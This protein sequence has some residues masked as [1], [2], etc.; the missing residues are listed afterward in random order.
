MIWLNYQHLRYFQVVAQEGSIAK[1]AEKLNLGQSAISIQLRQL[2]DQLQH[3][4]FQRRNRRLFLTQAGQVAL[5][6][7][8]QIFS[9][10]DELTEVLQEG[11][12]VRRVHLEIGVLDSVPKAVI[13]RLTDT[14]REWGP[15][16][17]TVFEG[18]GDYLFREL[19]AHRIDLVVS[20]YQPDIGDLRRFVIRSLGRQPVSVFGTRRFRELVED[21]PQ[22]LQGEPFL[23]PTLHSK[24]RHD[25]DHF[26]RS[27]KLTVDVVMETQDTSVQKLMGLRGDGLFALPDFAGNPMVKEKKLIRLGTLDG[28]HEELFLVSSP[29]TIANPVADHLMEKAQLEF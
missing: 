4:L 25:L 1:A 12:F 28:V 8:N 21:F 9:L 6:Y 20:D 29:R 14:A 10:G 5:E 24:R 22:S 16:T 13:Q 15:C 23:L 26:F 2:E 7:A 19:L 27:N 17:I 3:V 11:A 18:T